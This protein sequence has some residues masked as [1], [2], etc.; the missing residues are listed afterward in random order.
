MQN[1]VKM[2]LKFGLPNGAGGM[3]PAIASGQLKTHLRA[4]EKQTN[5]ILRVWH[6][7]KD[8]RHWI[9]VE[10]PYKHETLFNLFFADVKL[11]MKPEPL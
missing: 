4:F 5:C 11:F 3:A 6:F 8:H 7:S 2:L 10:V 1:P 9:G